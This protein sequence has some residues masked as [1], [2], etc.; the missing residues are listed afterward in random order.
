MLRTALQSINRQT[1]KEKI[2]TVIVS[3]NANGRGSDD[4]CEEFPDLPI[5]YIFRDPALRALDH[6]LSLF[7]EAVHLPAKYVAILHDDDWW[8]INHLAAG[9]SALER[10]GESLA[11][12]SASFLVHGECSWYLQC[13]N[14]SVWIATG[15]QSLTEVAKLDRKQA[16]LACISG[17]AAHY[18]SLI[19]EKQTLLECFRDVAATGNLFDNDRLLFLEMAKRSPV[20]VNLVPEV[21][22]R[23]H[24]AQDQSSF[25]FQE[26]SEHV[27][28]ATRTVLEFCKDEGID[29]VREF[30]RLYE[31]C[32][33]ESYRPYIT[34]TFDTRVRLELQRHN[35]M[36]ADRFPKPA[37]NATWF[38]REIC[39]PVC[40]RALRKF[41]R[42]VR[43]LAPRLN[44]PI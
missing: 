39:P 20:L 21:F 33:V 2:G 14:E 9:L 19:A 11:Y 10:D 32:P 7:Q 3:E 40:W 4:I 12:W 43:P 23:L 24:P 1:A 31:V 16:G 30:D 35:A 15:F 5:Q 25:S 13:W 26:S 29:V 44:R 38:A 8:G 18:S 6:G 28:A 37:R 17:G 41:Y 42:L 34:A 27:A 36:P 22:V